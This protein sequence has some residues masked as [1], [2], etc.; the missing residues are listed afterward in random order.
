MCSR[1]RLRAVDSVV[2]CDGVHVDGNNTV[3]N[4]GEVVSRAKYIAMVV[5][6]CSGVVMALCT[7]SFNGHLLRWSRWM[8]TVCDVQCMTD[9]HRGGTPRDFNGVRPIRDS[10]NRPA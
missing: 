5:K 1:S 8:A 3:A 2:T 4:E 6:M 10:V 9:S 7:R